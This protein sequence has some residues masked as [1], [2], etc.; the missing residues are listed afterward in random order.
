MFGV[1][2]VETPLDLPDDPL[3]FE[4]LIDHHLR[5][6][7]RAHDI[8]RLQFLHEEPVLPQP[9]DQ[10]FDD[11]LILED[12]VDLPLQTRLFQNVRDRGAHGYVAREHQV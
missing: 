10:F 12:R 4:T 1:I 3:Q 7:D 9:H 6:N 11:R 8:R 5:L 2:D